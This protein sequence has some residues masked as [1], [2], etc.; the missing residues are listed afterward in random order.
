MGTYGVFLVALVL[1][2]NL[3]LAFLAKQ[4]EGET[5]QVRLHLRISELATDKTFGIENGASLT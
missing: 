2:L 3:R 4:F 1:Q 5:L